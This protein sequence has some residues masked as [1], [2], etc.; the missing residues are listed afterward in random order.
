MNSNA[1]LAY[2]TFPPS[3]PS[4]RSDDATGI[5][6]PPSTSAQQKL[7]LMDYKSH[8]PGTHGCFRNVRF[9]TIRLF[10][11]SAVL[12]PC[13]KRLR[14]SLSTLKPMNSRNCTPANQLY[15]IMTV[16]SDRRRHVTCDVTWCCSSCHPAYYTRTHH[17]H[18]V[19]SRSYKIEVT[20]FSI[21]TYSKS[22]GRSQLNKTEKEKEKQIQKL[23]FQDTPRSEERRVGK[24]C[25]SRWSPYH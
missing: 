14:N 7:E 25:R 5:W 8:P 17:N 4:H 19:T 12:N 20:R 18:Q 21:R 15:I 2:S 10:L 11:D 13:T 23:R 22:K 16:C 24:E 3:L 6:Q 1:S 9:A